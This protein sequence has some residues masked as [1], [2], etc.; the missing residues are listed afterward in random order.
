MKRKFLII[1]LLIIIVSTISIGIGLYLNRLSKP[2]YIFSKGI[3]II[4]N[5][6]DSYTDIPKD[7][8]M[9]DTYELNGKINFELD[10]EFYK[11]DKS[12][13][14]SFK[15]YNLIN[16]L[17]K[18][19]TTFLIQKNQ[20]KK[21]GYFELNQDIDK[22]N[23]I[24][25]KYYIAD[26]TKYYFINGVLN[27]FVNDGSCNYF[28]NI[29]SNNSEKENI[30]YLYNFITKSIKNSLEEEYFNTKDT[31]D[32]INN[33]E[34]EVYKVSMRLNNKNIKEILNKVLKALKNDKKASTLLNNINKDILKT[35]LKDNTQ[36]LNKNEYYDITIYTTKILHKPLKYQ[37]KHVDNNDIR[38]YIYEGDNKKGDFYYLENDLLKYKLNLVLK[39]NEIDSKILDESNK[40][41]GEF[42]LEKNKYDTTISYAVNQEDKKVDLI[43]S[44]SYTKVV[45]NKSF[46]NTKKLSFKYIE[47]KEN[48]LNGEISVSIKAINK[49]NI[50]V[51]ISKAKLKSNLTDKEKENINKYYETII[52][53]LEK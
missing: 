51:D 27:E 36:I 12:N 11:K 52:N 45:K 3:D 26:S 48:K 9:K 44:D 7:L 39:N 6:V 23:I 15:K 49:P 10:S 42:K 38:T 22:E 25:T 30:D 2:E 13:Q 53:R 41:I 33:K 50:L 1:S 29:T 19:E 46:I 8:N 24:N 28:E 37:V 14:E 18:S 40:K 5:K 16:N 21:M 32:T 35:K 17:N 47:N 31:K 20:N 34:I 43:Y 4:K